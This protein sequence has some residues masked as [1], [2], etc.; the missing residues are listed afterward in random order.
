MNVETKVLVPKVVTQMEHHSEY[1][2]NIY[3]R[4]PSL[5]SMYRSIYFFLFKIYMEYEIFYVWISCCFV[6]ILI[7]ENVMLQDTL[8]AN[9]IK[10]DKKIVIDHKIILN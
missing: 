3:F 8:L 2:M 6:F 1:N 5:I 7:C 4:L 9:Y 10:I